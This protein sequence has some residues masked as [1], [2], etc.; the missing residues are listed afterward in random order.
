VSEARIPTGYRWDRTPLPGDEPVTFD[1]Q[2]WDTVWERNLNAVERHAIAMSVWRRCRPDDLFEAIVA[3][4][5]ARRWRRHARYLVVIYGLW[6]T[7]WGALAM[8]DLRPDAVLDSPL[9]PSCAML[10]VLVIVG[11]FAVRRRL[12]TYLRVHATP[13]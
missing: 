10:G 11:C 1:D 9:S 6:T 12:A 7:F 8:H 4:E 2:L 5:L 13:I 3:R